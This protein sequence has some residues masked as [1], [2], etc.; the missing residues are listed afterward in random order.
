MYNCSVGSNEQYC[1]AR[2]MESTSDRI[3]LRRVSLL[4]IL[5]N[6]CLLGDVLA[7]ALLYTRHRR[8]STRS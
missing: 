2:Q 7:A 8:C 6:G 5:K 3:T 1:E 4:A